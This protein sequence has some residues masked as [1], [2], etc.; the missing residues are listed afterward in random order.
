MNLLFCGTPKFS[1]DILEKLIHIY[2]IKAVFT[3]LDKP[4]GRKKALKPPEV[5][6]V[7]L[8]YNLALFQPANKDELEKNI[9][10]INEKIDAIIVVA[11]GMFLNKNITDNFF[12]INLHG[13]ILPYFRGA[14]PVQT[15]IINDFKHFGLSLIHM[16]EI[17]DGGDILATRPLLKEDIPAFRLSDIFDFLAFH[18]VELICKTLGNLS[19]VMPRTQMGEYATYCK[20]ITREDGYLNLEDAK[21]CFLKFVA[22]EV[23]PSVYISFNNKKLKII[24]LE[25]ADEASLND[26]AQILEIYKDSIKIACARGSLIIK[27]VVLEGR[28]EMSAISFLQS[29]NLTLNSFLG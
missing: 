13:S 22:F 15:S 6:L 25:I 27:K 1:A 20:K 7:S 29:N 21:E 28:K 2:S 9:F 4:F 3:Q 17:M 19:L 23:W 16:N 24:D 8:K 5:K 18:G 14:S 10:S 11:F 26:K 12:C